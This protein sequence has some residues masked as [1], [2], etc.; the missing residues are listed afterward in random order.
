MGR[1]LCARIEVSFS[2]VV[3]RNLTR[4]RNPLN[5]IYNSAEI[6]MES[7]SKL[8]EEAGSNSTIQVSPEQLDEDLD[9]LNTILLCAKHQKTIADDILR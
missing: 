3:W 6:L 7:I 1:S 9:A 2:S 4:F 5:A 8:R